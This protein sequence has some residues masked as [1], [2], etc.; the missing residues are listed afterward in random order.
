MGLLIMVE[1][2]G[3]VVSFDVFKEKFLCDLEGCNGAC[4]IEGDAGAPI[5][6]DEV[7]EVE[8]LLPEIWDELLPEAREVINKQ[9]ISYHDRSGE[10]VTSIVNGKDCVFT[11]YDERGCCYCAIE[12]AY[13]QGRVP[14]YKPVSCHLYPIRVGEY[15]PYRALNYDRWD[16]C[17]MA[18][19]K[20]QKENLPIY[21]FLKEPLIR[22]FGEDWYAEL[23]LVAE[24]LANQGII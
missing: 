3:V 8:A 9:G 22:R 12:R 24:E 21:K 1:V 20:G 13:R 14:F 18:V 17:K 4:C 7:K 23:E 19:L 5:T 11:C 6:P 2:N 15:G 16:V 10:L